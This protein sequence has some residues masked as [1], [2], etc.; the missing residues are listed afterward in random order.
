MTAKFDLYPQPIQVKSEGQ[1]RSCLIKQ[2]SGDGNVTE[3]TLWYLYPHNIP[4]PEDDDCDS[5]LLASLL[6]AMKLGA[7]IKLHGKASK[8]LLS[9]LTEL[10]MIWVT[11]CPQTY[12]IVNIKVDEVEDKY[13][14]QNNNT[15]VAFSGGLDASFSAYRHATKQAGFANKNLIAGVLVHGFDIPLN[16][17]KGFHRAKNK[18]IETLTDINLSLLDVKTNLRDAWD[19][20]WA[21]YYATAVA[22]VL[23]SLYK[24]ASSGLIGSGPTY[25][26]LFTPCGSHPMTDPLLS[27]SSFRIIHDGA[28]FS[29]SD[30]TSTIANWAIGVKNLRVCW[31]GDNRD[32]NCGVCEKC[33]R[34]RLNFLVSGVSNPECFDEPLNESHFSSIKL[35]S[36]GSRSDWILIRN[37]ILKTK[38][39]IEFLPNIEKVLKRKH[40]AKLSFILP[41]NSK[42]RK[43]VKNIVNKVKR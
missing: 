20:N 32:K 1:Y 42:R 31:V 38:R 18:A 14:L 8:E 17:Y 16:D 36:D 34:T 3:K 15:I 2:T 27:T 21:H 41:P 39:G 10:Q 43:F 22:S 28:A 12:T 4:L 33:V 37:K 24:V 40:S 11:W 35:T 13:T 6:P 23:T 25:Q 7:S 30:K 26:L 9:N 5:Y 29:R 19:I